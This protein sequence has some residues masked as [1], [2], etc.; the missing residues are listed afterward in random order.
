L[1]TR[2]NGLDHEQEHAFGFLFEEAHALFGGI[3]FF[4][5][6]AAFATRPKGLLTGGSFFI[7]FLIGPARINFLRY[8]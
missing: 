2:Q 4:Q 3:A 5:S 8:P 7:I 6:E 1:S